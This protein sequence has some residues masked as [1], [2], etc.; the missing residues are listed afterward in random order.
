MAGRPSEWQERSAVQDRNWDYADYQLAKIA[1]TTELTVERRP[2]RAKSAGVFLKDDLPAVQA[3]VKSRDP[4]VAA[5]AMAR[6]R[7]ACMK[8]HVSED[9]PYFTLRE[10]DRRLT[11]IRPE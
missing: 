11:P 4:A 2:K 10:P 6:L 7:S 3:G 5:D 1:L 9:V 8:C